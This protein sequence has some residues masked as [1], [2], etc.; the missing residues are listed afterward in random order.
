[1]GQNREEVCVLR[2]R[3]LVD[4]ALIRTTMIKPNSQESLLWE[5]DL[6]RNEPAANKKTIRRIGLSRDKPP[7]SLGNHGD[8]AIN[9]RNQPSSTS[10]AQTR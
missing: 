1:M 4:Q 2:R 3:T 8:R 10:K 7:L 9:S 5:S 6:C